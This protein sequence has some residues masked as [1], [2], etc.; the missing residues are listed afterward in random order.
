MVRVYR[1]FTGF[2]AHLVKTALEQ[3]EIPAIVRNEMLAG[4]AGA[5]PLADVMVEVWIPADRVADAQ[6]VLEALSPHKGPAGQLSL[7][8][9]EHPEG[10]LS[11]Q[12]GAGALSEPRTC[13]E[14]GAECPPEFDEC[15][16]CQTVLS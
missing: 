5:M 3:H 10:G 14:C 2:E 6:P 11:I 16:R 4:L 1:A 8:D 15:W 13:P 7:A 12:D 9:A